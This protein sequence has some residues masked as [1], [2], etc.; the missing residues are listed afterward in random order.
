MLMDKLRQE[1][2]R[3]STKG[4]YYNAWKNFNKFI[5]KLDSIPKSWEERATLYCGYLLCVKKLQ[6]ST[7]KS[8]MSGIKSVLIDDG[9]EWAD[10]KLLLNALTRSC[11]MKNDQVKTRLPIQKGFLDM[12]LCK[13][14]RKFD[15]Q[16]YL[17]AM[18]ISAILI[19]YY[20]L[21]RIGEITES[22]HSIK[23]INVHSAKNRDQILIILYSSKTHGKGNVPQKI[24][25]YGKTFIEVQDRKKTINSFKTYTA[26]CQFC[27]VWWLHYYI[28]MRKEIDHEKEQLFV[29]SDGSNL[30]ANHI[31][32]LLRT[33]IRSFNLN[34]LLYDTHSLRIG[35]ATDLFKYGVN[36]DDIK[37]LG[38]WKSNAVYKYLK[39]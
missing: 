33:T 27:P 29:F 7:V 11:K 14:Q 36:I 35:R 38:R 32:Q 20:G 37:Q 8:Y 1:K 4:S 26:D 18:Y 39:H 24:K 16:P 25:I 12:I 15:K 3:D 34:D 19:S 28:D 5:V 22:M 21:C 17:E 13:I 23:A 10:G 9:Y 6:S 30:K 2:H 31:R